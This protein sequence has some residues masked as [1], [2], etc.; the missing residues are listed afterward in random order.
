MTEK[1][2]IKVNEET[3]EIITNIQNEEI[4]QDTESYTI[5]KQTDGKFRKEMKYK[6]VYTRTPQTEEEMKELFKVFNAHDDDELVKP[7]ALL[8]GK[9]FDIINFYTNPYTSFDEETGKNVNGVTTTIET[10]NGYVATSSK[11]V[12]YTILGLVDVFGYPNTEGYKPIRVKVVGKK[13]ENGV[14]I[15]LSLV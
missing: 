3:G 13:M 7:L 9:E 4:V 11:S 2:E 10:E 15:N 8:R 5:Y 6:K 1:N 12:Y 14:Q